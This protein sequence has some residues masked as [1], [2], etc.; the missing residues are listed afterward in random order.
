MTVTRELSQVQSAYKKIETAAVGG[1]NK[2]ADKFVDLYLTKEGKSVEEARTRLTEEQN[3]RKASG[4]AG[5]R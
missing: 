5:N 4:K 1:F 3:N 2:I